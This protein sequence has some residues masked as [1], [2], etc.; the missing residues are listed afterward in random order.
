[1]TI[2]EA[3]GVKAILERV[4]YEYGVPLTATSGQSG[5]FIVNEI[6][7]YV[8]GEEND[9]RV[10]L[11]IGDHELRGPAEQIE[12]NTKAYLEEH[13]ERFFCD[14]KWVK[15]AL[16][17]EQVNEDSAAGERLRSLALTK[18][19]NRNKPPKEYEA[20]ECEALGQTEIVSIYRGYLDELRRLWGLEPIE[21]LRVR[22]RTQRREVE[23]RLRRLRRRA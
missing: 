2:C 22:E 14:D 21:A 6:V 7:P 10:V 3:R 11:Y 20:V 19:D 16:T 8:E 15:I 17:S 12:A 18:V 4:A 5:G 9:E 23:T 13:G 1:L